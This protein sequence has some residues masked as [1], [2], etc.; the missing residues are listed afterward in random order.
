ME[1]Y[2]KLLNISYSATIEQINSIC[3]KKI[4]SINNNKF[5]NENYENNKILLKKYKKAIVIFND[6]NYK[7]TYD[8]YI[9]NKLIQSNTLNKKRND[10]DQSYIYNRTFNHKINHASLDLSQTEVLRSLN[11]GLINDIKPVYDTPLDSNFDLENVKYDTNLNQDGSK[12][13]I[14]EVLYSR[15][16]ETPSNLNNTYKKF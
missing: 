10:F 5:N 13:N 9:K 11:T 6:T 8:T 4:E 2:Y 16:F 15:I 7:S 1:D 12:K 14:D 3:N